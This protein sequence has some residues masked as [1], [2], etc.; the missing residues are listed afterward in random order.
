MAAARKLTELP[1][2]ESGVKKEPHTRHGVS[3]LS[4]SVEN[5]AF[6]VSLHALSLF[7]V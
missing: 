1:E 3:H 5:V 7:H 4:Q 6:G 2:L